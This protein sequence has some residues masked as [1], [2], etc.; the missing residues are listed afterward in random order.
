MRSSAFLSVR[1]PQGQLRHGASAVI[2]AAF[3]T[4]LAWVALQ[5]QTCGGQTTP[6]THPANAPPSTGGTEPAT[7][8]LPGPWPRLPRCI[9][10]LNPPALNRRT[11]TP[12]SRH[13][14]IVSRPILGT[15]GERPWLALW[16]ADHHQGVWLVVV[17]APLRASRGCSGS[18][19]GR[20]DG[21][22]AQALVV[23]VVWVAFFV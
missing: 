13:E 19:V 18:S 2:F 16:L 15:P 5:V 22:R 11:Q 9:D 14:R 12:I 10:A 7:W 1:G 4:S 8:R 21:V 20:N 17:A 3:A 23:V 6:R